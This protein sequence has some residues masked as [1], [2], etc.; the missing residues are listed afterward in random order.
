MQALVDADEN[1]NYDIVVGISGGAINLGSFAKFN[2]TDS[3]LVAADMVAMWLKLRHHNMFSKWSN[4]IMPDFRVVPSLFN[5]AVQHTYL[6]SIFD[7]DVLATTDRRVYA[8]VTN[9]DTYQVKLI[10]NSDP[11]FLDSIVA[12]SAFPMMYN[13]V[14]LNDTY[15]ID[16]AF[17]FTQPVQNI[18]DLCKESTLNDTGNLPTS[19]HIDLMLPHG[20]F[21]SQLDLAPAADG[22]NIFDVMYRVGTKLAASFLDNDYRM[23]SDPAQNLTIRV[24]KPP[25]PLDGLYISFLHSKQ[26]IKQGYIDTIKILADE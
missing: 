26:Y 5:T 12:S 11:T 7:A 3:N 23:Q 14:K 19:I 8:A 6:R 25:A 20:D 15:F 2:K 4:L 13:P 18:I 1:V 21:S 10:P 24:F 22:M 16:G 17:N 9:M